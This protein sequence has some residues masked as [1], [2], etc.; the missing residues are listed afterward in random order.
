MT[1]V[2][3]DVTQMARAQLFFVILPNNVQERS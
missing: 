1:D 2:D 3:G